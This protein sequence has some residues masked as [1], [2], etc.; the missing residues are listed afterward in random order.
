MA[1]GGIQLDAQWIGLKEVQEALGVLNGKEKKAQILKAA[2][3]KAIE[4]AFQR[5]KQITPV[6]PTGNLKRAITKKVAIY[7]QDGNAVGIVGFKRAGLSDSVSAA[8]GTVRA[9]P[10]RAFH[11]WWLEEGTK[12]RLIS[13][14]SPPKS[15][16]RSSY[17]KPSFERRTYQMTRKGKQF[18]VSGHSVSSHPVSAHTV[19]DPNSY[20]YASS[21]NRLGK[22]KILKFR[23]GEKGFITD[24][25][26]PNA[27]FKK[28]RNPIKIEKMPVGGFDGQPPLKTTFEQT[29]SQ[30]ADILQR[31]LRLSLEQALNVISSR[32]TGT[33]G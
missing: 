21:F 29:K 26:Y 1:V 17:V 14:P 22:F 15:Y 32:S 25:A 24:P 3:T 11:Q 6:G 4:P 8:G 9:G 30:I 20:Y 28:S 5:L 2:L 19:N 10:D 27:F 31:E 13:V 7:P 18:T 23:G 16:N 33:I 12:E